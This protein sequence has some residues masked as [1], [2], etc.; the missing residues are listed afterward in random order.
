MWQMWGFQQPKWLMHRLY[1]S[2]RLCALISE[3]EGCAIA[4]DS[5]K[6]SKGKAQLLDDPNAPIDLLDMSTA[7]A[8]AR[9]AAGVARD[10]SDELVEG[11]ARDASGK[12]LISEELS[13][14]KGKEKDTDFFAPK[15]GKRRRPREGSEDSDLEDMGRVFGLKEAYRKTADADSLK[16][17]SKYAHSQATAR[18]RRTAA[19]AASKASSHSKSDPAAKF[20]AKKAD[21]DTKGGNKVEPYA[22]WKLDR[23]LLNTRSQKR[24]SAKA[25]LGGSVSVAGPARGAK[26][27]KKF[28]RE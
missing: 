27:R 6:A 13:T 1:I 7:R 24:R 22:Y 16:H 26:A 2:G 11:F 5:E 20:K 10:D 18:S 23:N 19:T 3:H 25:K 15:Q 21:G 9:S 17:V 28:R 14:R 8:L 12:M 4:V